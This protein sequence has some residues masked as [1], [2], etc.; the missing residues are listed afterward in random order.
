MN[1][2]NEPNASK[3]E[4]FL[5]WYKR[6][7]YT[8]LVLRVGVTPVCVSACTCECVCVCERER[9]R[10]RGREVGTL[11]FYFSNSPVKKCAKH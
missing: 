8:T 7:L 2:T 3:V 4:L 10:E 11:C 9:E 1:N 6:N 5:D